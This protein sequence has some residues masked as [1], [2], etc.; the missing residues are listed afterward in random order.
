MTEHDD[1]FIQ[2][3]KQI[4]GCKDELEKHQ[5]LLNELKDFKDM[6]NKTNE[7]IEDKIK[8]NKT[9]AWDDLFKAKDEIANKIEDLERTHEAYVESNS[10]K[11]NETKISL[12]SE[13]TTLREES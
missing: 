2:H 5:Q 1:K 3:T 11:Q 13:I 4:R 8:K 6:Q 7:R 10:F 12:K 9:A